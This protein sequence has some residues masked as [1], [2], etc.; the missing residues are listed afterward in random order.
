MLCSHCRT[1]LPDSSEFCLKCGHRLKVNATRTTSPMK[2]LGWVGLGIGIAAI[3]FFGWRIATKGGP[4]PTQSQPSAAETAAPGSGQPKATSLASAPKPRILSAQEI[5]QKANGGMVLIETFNDEGHPLEQ[6]SGFVASNDGAV[7]TNYHVIRGA[8]RATAK[9]GDGTTSDVS[10]V[11]AFDRDHDVAVV[12]LASPA[13]AALPIGDSGK[14][15]VGEKIVAIGSPLGLQNTVSEGI[16]SGLRNGIIQMSNPISPGSSGGAVFD[17]YGNVIGISVATVAAGQ[18][19]NFAVPI[20][21]ARAY[22]SGG[23][24]QTFADVISENT[25]T[26]DLLDGSIDVPP[27]KFKSWSI[28]VNP[29]VMNN[30]EIAGQVT[31]SGG[32]GGL[33]TLAVYVNVQGKPDP[34]YSC[35]STS[36][37]IDKKLSVPGMYAVVLDNTASP[38]F[39]RTVTGKLSEKYV[40]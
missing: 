24:P 19:L 30:T 23:N 38:L 32:M 31:S 20:N 14:A 33:I 21:W 7:L 4:A 16:I 28:L 9:F 11:L 37:T 29:N 34:I 13:K 6:G 12:R 15:K 27:T 5:F 40:H 22:L 18:N 36:C 26:N 39:G 10:G 3:G 35:R 17:R 2:S 25:I 8:S 1:E